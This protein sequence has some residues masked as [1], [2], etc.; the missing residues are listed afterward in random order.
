MSTSCCW[1]IPIV[2]ECVGVQV[3]LWYPLTMLG[4][5]E[6][7]RDVSCI[8]AVQIDIIFSFTFVTVGWVTRR[9][10]ALWKISYQQSQRFSFGRP[11]GTSPWKNRLVASSYLL[12]VIGK[13]FLQLPHPIITTNIPTPST[14]FITFA[15]GQ[16]KATFWELQVIQPNQLQVCGTAREDENVTQTRKC[17]WPSSDSWR[18]RKVPS[19]VPSSQR[20]CEIRRR[21]DRG[22]LSRRRRS[23]LWMWNSVTHRR[24]SVVDNL[25][26]TK[27]VTFDFFG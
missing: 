2:D 16:S 18:R 6:S 8:G 3:K 19:L 23:T 15:Q 4:I 20:T 7:L 1:L 21:W 14:Q 25:L 22:C 9:E 13:V 17:V 26:T 11:S 12:D 10:S 24:S 5:P 27:D